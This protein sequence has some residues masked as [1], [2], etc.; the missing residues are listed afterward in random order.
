MNAYCM[1]PGVNFWEIRRLDNEYEQIE[2]ENRK[3]NSRDAKE[4]NTGGGGIYI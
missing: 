2:M 3:Q 4:D 1:F